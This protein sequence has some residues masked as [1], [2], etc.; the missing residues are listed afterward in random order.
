MK[1]ILI[2]AIVL[3]VS[4]STFAHAQSYQSSSNSQSKDI[5]GSN[6]GYASSG[7]QPDNWDIYNGNS[8]RNSGYS[9]S[10]SKDSTTYQSQAAPSHHRNHKRN[11]FSF[12]VNLPGQETI[13][14]NNKGIYSKPKM[15][16]VR[17]NTGSPIPK[18]AVIGGWESQGTQYVCR[19]NY[20]GL[21][22][23]KLYQG[24]CIIGY[25]GRQIPFHDY[26]ILVSKAK[27]HWASARFGEIPRGA[28]QGGEE[29]GRPVFICQANY[30]NGT[31]SGKVVGQNCNF[32]WGQGEVTVPIYNVLMTG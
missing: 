13:V 19:V 28:L 17:M 15:N 32:A 10:T 31:H 2:P 14:V 20:N 21:Q 27:V 22:P 16:W 12:S 26:E 3:T 24:K 29:N 23:G 6:S 4:L 25:G 9:S 18:H 30:Q 5:N 11:D 1:K 8:N 7:S